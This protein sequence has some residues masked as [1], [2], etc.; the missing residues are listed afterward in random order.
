MVPA[1][2][3]CWNTYS[4]PTPTCVVPASRFAQPQT[5]SSW[6]SGSPPARPP[7]PAAPACSSSAA[8]PRTPSAPRAAGSP[9][10]LPPA[11][12]RQPP[13]SPSLSSECPPHACISPGPRPFAGS[14]CRSRVCGY[15]GCQWLLGG[16]SL[17][18]LRLSYL[19][20]SVVSSAGEI[21]EG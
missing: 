3:Y 11:G 20:P 8:C 4:S 7:C 12:G 6:C 16:P 9:P 17:R 13:A 5:L 21:D 1:I 14:A 15:P 10:S 18:D 19:P 2:N